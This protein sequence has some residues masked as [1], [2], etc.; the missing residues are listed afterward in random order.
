MGPR[1]GG[2]FA[3]GFA[4]EEEGGLGGPGGGGWDFAGAARRERPGDARRGPKGAAAVG[5]V[6][7]RIRARL[8]ARANGGG[9]GEA[10]SSEGEDD[11]DDG[12][13]GGLL[14]GEEPVTSSDSEGPAGGGV[15][16][17]SSSGDEGGSESEAGSSSGEEEGEDEGAPGPAPPRPG[18]VEREEL[19]DSSSESEEDEAEDDGG[20]RGRR[21]PRPNGKA[22]A[23]G[24]FFAQT[25]DGTRF[26]ARAFTELHLSRPL[27]KSCTALGF[28]KPTPIQV[29]G[30]T[31]RPIPPF[32]PPRNGAG[33]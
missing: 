26:A 7:A 12:S 5:G 28:S 16:Q 1:G 13:G 30:A 3:A 23:A 18:A 20:A 8:E 31:P 25:P 11:D 32:S 21:G 17:E 2:D 4:F 15:L 6:D 22:G 24:G 14:P 29:S 33:G 10:E 19:A 27:V 9:S